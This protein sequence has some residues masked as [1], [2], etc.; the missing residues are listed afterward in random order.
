MS[1]VVASLCLSAFT[2]HASLSLSLR[3]SKASGQ[4]WGGCVW[5]G[6]ASEKKFLFLFSSS[7]LDTRPVHFIFNKNRRK[8]SWCFFFSLQ[9]VAF[10][11]CWANLILVKSSFFVLLTRPKSPLKYMPSNF[12]LSST[13]SSSALLRSVRCIPWYKAASISSANIKKL[14]ARTLVMQPSLHTHIHK[15]THTVLTL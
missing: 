7:Y 13:S 8:C 15:H 4:C 14:F 10:G 9:N 11:F 2:Q 5:G 3:C 12:P 6:G 1:L